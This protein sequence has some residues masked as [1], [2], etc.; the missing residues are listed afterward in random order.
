M[1]KMGLFNQN[2]DRYENY[3]YRRPS[4]FGGFS[5]F[6]P[7]IKILLISNVFIFIVQYFF[8]NNYHIGKV[9]LGNWFL[10]YFALMPVGEGFMP[11][12][13]LT[14]QFMHGG[15]MHLFFNMFA[16][17]MFGMELENLWGSKK[18]LIY[19]LTCGVGAGLT[20][21]FIAPMLG[22]ALPTIGASGSVYGVLVAFGMLFPERPIFLYFLFPIRAKYFVLMYI[23]IEFL[24]LGGVSN[25]AHAAHL[26]GAAVGFFYVLL[27][28]RGIDFSKYF[29]NMK[30]DP[31]EPQRRGNVYR[32]PYYEKYNRGNEDISDADFY[33]V[34]K[35][36]DEVSQ[37]R[38]DEILDKISR[39]GYQNLTE[40]EKKI[41]F[42]ASKKIH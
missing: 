5:Y 1:F 34:N 7:V 32:N 39:E 9:P 33:D 24:S 10:S 13:L 2:K 31:Y 41:L 42:E 25:I 21:L 26:G 11:W 38:I 15:L 20:N 12:Q 16:L 23:V 19:Y 18:F 28:R 40:E 3:Q 29:R 27:T 22:P 14:Y 8:L 4:M 30:S 35:K 17:W 37:E 36:G 6:P